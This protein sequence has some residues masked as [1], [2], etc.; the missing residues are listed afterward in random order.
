MASPSIK[1][2]TTPLPQDVPPTELSIP[3]PDNVTLAKKRSNWF[4][5]DNTRLR[6][7]L[8]AAVG[9]LELANAGDFAANVWNDIP[10]PIY[11]IV[12][13]AIGGT[14]ALVISICAFFDSRKAWCNIKFLRRQ[15][16]YLETD[17]KRLGAESSRSHDVFIEITTRELRIEIINRWAMDVLMGGGALLISTGTYMAIGGANDKVFLA[18]NILSGYLGNAPIAL[19]GLISSIWAGFVVAK[20]RSHVKV[21]NKELQ[22][23]PT[24]PLLKQRCFRVNLFFILNGI[25]NVLG[26]V[27]SMLTAER[28]WG[29]VILIPVIVTSVFCNVWWRHRVGYD[30]TFISTLPD[31]NVDNITEALEATTQ[32][33]HAIQDGTSM[34]LEQIFGGPAALSEVLELFVKHDLFE[35]FSL[36][37]VTN[38]NVGH[39][40]L[41][42]QDARAQISAAS[43]LDIAEEHHPS[44][45]SVALIFLKKQ[46]PKHLLHR[47]RFLIEVLGTHLNQEKKSQTVEAEK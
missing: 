15:K 25:A 26:G 24:L 44:I 29:Y 21:A 45:L 11:A 12:F 3:G 37:L 39:L 17:K 32:L 16:K 6:N 9:F 33:R 46:G 42:A 22:G 14:A 4:C 28:W 38:K 5:V 23:S 43:I 7:N 20:M 30:R 34:N 1:E 10:V 35:Q 13:M 40:L 41:K 2:S 47:E 31:L 19:F 36:Q 18:S 27:G 8:F